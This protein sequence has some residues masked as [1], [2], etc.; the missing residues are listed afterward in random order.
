MKKV[1]KT[2]YIANDGEEFLT[3]EDCE[4]H[5]KFVKEIL[6]NIAYFCVRCNPD[7]AETGRYKHKIYIAVLSKH[8]HLH[9]E[10]AFE[11]ALRKFGHYLGESV[12]GYGFQCSFR[13]SGTSRTEYEECPPVEWRD[14]KLKSER[15][16]LSPEK[17][18]GFPD[19]FDYM[20]EWGLR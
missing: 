5:E 7:L 16:F 10:I 6:S 3:K 9:E 11:W 1:T 19:N 18:D 17:V 13:V 15:I 20:K 2:I 12:M 8:Y 14:F 4:K